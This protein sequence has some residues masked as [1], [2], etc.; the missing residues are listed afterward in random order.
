MGQSHDN[1]AWNTLSRKWDFG[2][3][4][5]IATAYPSDL[6]QQFQ[7]NARHNDDAG[8]ETEC[9][10]TITPAWRAPVT[11]IQKP[12]LLG[13]Q[14]LFTAEPGDQRPL[15]LIQSFTV[16][17]PG[18]KL[19]P[20]P[21]FGLSKD[22]AALLHVPAL[23]L[24]SILP[25]HWIIAVSRNSLLPARGPGEAA[26]DIRFHPGGQQHLQSSLTIAARTTERLGSIDIQG[27]NPPDPSG[28]A[29][30]SSQWP[31]ALGKGVPCP[32][33]KKPL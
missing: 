12:W 9:L 33:G 20:P 31:F 23:G 29:G 19:P 7:P 10:F 8:S 1:S 11:D 3:A 5:L 6:N 28:G 18:E 14:P 26:I 17:W 2:L 15:S 16:D 13:H 22:R 32:A 24:V 27:A 25:R 30:A 4:S 21:G